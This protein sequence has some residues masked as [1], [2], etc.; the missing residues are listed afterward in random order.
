MAMA[1][2]ST[3]ATAMPLVD[4]Q[5]SAKTCGARARVWG[6]KSRLVFQEVAL[7]SVVAQEES[8]IKYC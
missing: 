7:S 8:K 2:A 6:L 3:T 1:L 4:L 5:L